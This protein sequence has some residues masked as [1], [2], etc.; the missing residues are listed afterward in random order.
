MYSLTKGEERS[1]T[2]LAGLAGKLPFLNEEKVSH[3]FHTIAERLQELASDR[4]LLARAAI[5]AAANWLLDAAS[6]WVFLAAFFHFINPVYLLVCYGLA[7]VLAAIPITP[8]GLGIIEGV[9]IPTL[10][11]FGV[12]RGAA[13]LGVYS[14]RLINFWLPIPIGGLAYL[15]LKAEPGASRQRKLEELR[16]LSQKV[17]EHE[18]I[19]Q[20]HTQA[21]A[22]SGERMDSTR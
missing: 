6:L 17:S 22:P 20:P 7:N 1:A 3:L 14:Y 9:L 11:G 4:K 12:T 16:R 8:G 10:A 18:P 2:R 19:D 15:S 5:W 13:V 21:P